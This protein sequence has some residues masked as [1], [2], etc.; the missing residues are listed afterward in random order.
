MVRAAHESADPSVDLATI[1][2]RTAPTLYMAPPLLLADGPTVVFG[3]G[4]TCKT[5][6]ALRLAVA[7]ARGRRFLGQDVRQAPVLFVD[8]ESNPDITKLRLQAVFAGMDLEWRDF[9]FTYWPAGGRAFADMVPALRRKIREAD[10]G[11][12]FVDSAAQA[13]GADPEKADSALRYFNSVDS[14]EIPSTTIA[15]VARDG[16]DQYPFGS[17]FWHN[18]PRLTWNTKAEL[19]DGAQISHLGLF[20]RKAN[21]AAL[22]RP[23]G[24][25][26]EFDTGGAGIVTRV[27]FTRENLQAGVSDRANLTTRIR[28]ELAPGARTVKEL[29]KELDANTST[30]RAMLHQ[31]A[32]VWQLDEPVEDGSK[33]WGLRANG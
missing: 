19:Q 2:P 32:G 24:I 6:L 7:I 13:C 10:I 18:K 16:S 11:Y 14:L 31:M 4:G 20:N 29:A 26:L 15:H 12:L 5:Y 23:V 21:D 30:I 8:Y 33:K 3:D 27:R 1:T 25:R 17:V 9:P 28:A 22:Q